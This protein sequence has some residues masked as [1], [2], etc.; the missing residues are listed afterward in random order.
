MAIRFNR[1]VIEGL[2]V[3]LGAVFFYVGVLA[4]YDVPM[5]RSGTIGALNVPGL[6]H[7]G[8][9][10]YEAHLADVR[11]YAGFNGSQC[12]VEYPLVSLGRLTASSYP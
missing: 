5:V 4:R 7:D 1:E 10:E 9:Y 6:D 12:F 8:P 11:S 2:D 3:R